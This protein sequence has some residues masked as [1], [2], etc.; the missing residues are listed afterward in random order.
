MESE[1]ATRIPTDATTDGGAGHI[2]RGLRRLT[3]HLDEAA[4]GGASS[5]PETSYVQDVMVEPG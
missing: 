5:R 4:Y 2:N 3:C 1:D